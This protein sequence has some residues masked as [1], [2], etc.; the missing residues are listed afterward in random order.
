MK[1]RA[2]NEGT[3][4][5][6]TRIINGKK[7]TYWEAKVITG[8]EPITGKPI[9]KTFSGK[10]QAD[11]KEKMQAASVSVANKT[12][13]EPTKMT[14]E[15]W[16]NLWL[17][18]FCGS[19]KYKTI[20]THSSH[21]RNH[22]IP[23]LGKIKLSKLSPTQIQL[24]YNNLNLS[25]STIHSIHG[26]LSSLLSDAVELGYIPFNNASK[27]KAPPPKTTINPLSD[28][29]IK[30]FLSELE[31]ETYAALFKTILFTGLREAE[32]IGLTWDCID[33]NN[34][35]LRVYRQL[36]LQKLPVGFTFIPTKTNK[37]RLI[38]LSDYLCS[39]FQDLS[40]NI[41][42]PP[43]DSWQANHPKDQLVFLTTKGN[44]ILPRTIYAH[45]KKITTKI[46]IENAR[47]HDLRHTFATISFQ[48]GDD[49]KTVQQN[50]GHSNA[51]TTLNVYAHVS[52]T[53]FQNS[54]SRMQSYI[55]NLYNKK[56]PS[57]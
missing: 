34:K 19:M 30:A 7:Y 23:V 50:L 13:F 18:E 52:N 17:K 42:N 56:E 45:F 26:T 44:P 5:Q 1:K 15:E 37:S 2:N 51:S 3:L 11:V 53:M 6:R 29:E 39:I 27:A 31:H 21:I 8:Y 10:S 54:A 38:P 49:I 48:N 57:G 4:I 40:Q 46:G 14:V 24:F 47:V 25:A 36:Q 20:S 33:L 35:T 12:Y 22:I 43:P 28:D 9:R 32:A 41:P 55:D 16:C